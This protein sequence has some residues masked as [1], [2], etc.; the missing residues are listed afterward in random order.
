MNEDKNHALL[1]M[2]LSTCLHLH[3][4]SF[5]VIFNLLLSLHSDQL[6][7]RNQARELQTLLN[8]N[9]EVPITQYLP[10][11]NPFSNCIILPILL[12]NYTYVN[13][14]C[15]TLRP[16]HANTEAGP[17]QRKLIRSR[18]VHQ[19]NEPQHTICTDSSAVTQFYSTKTNMST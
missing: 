16:T 18:L 9:V 8:G 7:Q 1:C 17:W 13:R 4:S 6:I 11:P 14:K 5:I 12:A 3:F 10:L 15:A 2:M 19:I